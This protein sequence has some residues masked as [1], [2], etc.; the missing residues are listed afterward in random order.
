MIE[1]TKD[2]TTKKK[3][4][5]IV[6]ERQLS[7]QRKRDRTFKIPQI[8]Y[9]PLEAVRNTFTGGTFFE[10]GRELEI[11]AAVGD[12][13]GAAAHGYRKFAQKHI[14]GFRGSSFNPRLAESDPGR[15]FDAPS[16]PPR[17]GGDAAPDEVV[18]KDAGLVDE[19]VLE[20]DSGSSAF[21]M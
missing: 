20:D 14:V 7:Q 16:R 5:D 21:D 19:A 6:R 17:P 1:E 18:E 15:K 3:L 11:P 10:G 8:E 12:T 9:E 2:M 4:V 13:I